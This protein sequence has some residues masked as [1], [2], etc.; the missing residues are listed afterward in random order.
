MSY[1][2][3]SYLFPEKTFWARS[4]ES[5]CATAEIYGC[6]GCGR[7]EY[8]V[9][10]RTEEEYELDMLYDQIYH[11]EFA[12]E[13][14]EDFEESDPNTPDSLADTIVLLIA[15]YLQFDVLMSAYETKKEKAVC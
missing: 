12:E 1:L 13:M 10:D 3:H 14:M 2:E 11:A 4:P 7:C 9:D 6:I 15:L 8:F 5:S